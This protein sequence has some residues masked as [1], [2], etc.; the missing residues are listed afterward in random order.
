MKK[1]ILFLFFLAVTILLC[2]SC[3]KYKY[4]VNEYSLQSRFSGTKI[5]LK[6]RCNMDYRNI[7]YQDGKFFI[8]D[9]K[10][11]DLKNKTNGE[12]FYEASDQLVF[13]KDG[14]YFVIKQLFIQNDGDYA[15][16]LTSDYCIIEKENEI[17][18]SLDYVQIPFPKFLVPFRETTLEGAYYPVYTVKETIID[19][20]YRDYLVNYYRNLDAKNMTKL[21]KFD[22]HIHIK[23]DNP[24]LERDYEIYIHFSEDSGI[25]IE[26]KMNKKGDPLI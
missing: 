4:E 21:D 16:Q 7:N 9:L 3:K 12:L 24:F 8:T 1:K 25:F 23:I 19:D 17:S 11:K 18:I 2:S 13:I 14:S 6:C 20:N 15:Y 26:A 10:L 22:D 5:T